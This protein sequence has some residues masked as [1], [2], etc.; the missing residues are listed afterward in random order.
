MEWSQE[1][2]NNKKSHFDFDRCNR[3]FFTN[4][5][6]KRYFGYNLKFIELRVC[7]VYF[8]LRKNYK[9]N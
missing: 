8:Q 5:F 2:T 6:D 3:Y 9:E 4:N 7:F 1:D